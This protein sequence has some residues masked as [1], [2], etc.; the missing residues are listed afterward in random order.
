MVI[1]RRFKNGRTNLIL[2]DKEKNRIVQ[3]HDSIVAK[4]LQI[5]DEAMHDYVMMRINAINAAIAKTHGKKPGETNSEYQ[6]RLVLAN[7]LVKH[8]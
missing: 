2:R 7:Q 3:Q 5:K 1:G 4:V 6:R 8:E